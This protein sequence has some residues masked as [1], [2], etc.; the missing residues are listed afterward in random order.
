MTPISSTSNWTQSLWSI[1]WEQHYEVKLLATE[2]LGVTSLVL[3]WKEKE[4]FLFCVLLPWG[5]SCTYSLT[6]LRPCPHVHGYLGNVASS[7]RFC[8]SSTPKLCSRSLETELCEVSIMSRHVVQLRHKYIHDRQTWPNKPA[9]RTFYTYM[10]SYSSSILRNRGVRM[11]Y[12]GHCDSSNTTLPRHRLC[13]R[14]MRVNS[15]VF[16]HFLLDG[17]LF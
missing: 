8:L 5:H 6:L 1:V 9:H 4:S 16:L 14:C 3:E 12:G 11:P 17:N 13:R 7:I 2:K 10:Y 15:I